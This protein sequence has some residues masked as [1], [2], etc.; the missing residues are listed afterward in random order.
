MS[1]RV[2]IDK[3]GNSP[4]ERPAVNRASGTIPPPLGV[5]ACR[6]CHARTPPCF[7]SAAVARPVRQSTTTRAPSHQHRVAMLENSHLRIRDRREASRQLRPLSSIKPRVPPAP[8]AP[9]ESP[10]PKDRPR[11]SSLL[12]GRRTVQVVCSTPAATSSLRRVLRYYRR[13]AMQ[14]PHHSNRLCPAHR[15]HPR[16][17]HQPCPP[18]SPCESHPRHRAA[19]ARA[20]CAFHRSPTHRAPLHEISATREALSKLRTSNVCS[21]RQ[22][23]AFAKPSR[24]R[25]V[26]RCAVWARPLAKSGAPRAVAAARLARLARAAS[27]YG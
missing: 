26:L 13:C 4:C 15:S 27:G 3:L 11:Q 21:P 22:R 5:A 10:A 16:P 7:R 17:D 8:T 14:C 18:P 12:H 24:Q 20:P 2:I 9:T 23:E 1:L 19:P 6:A 25:V